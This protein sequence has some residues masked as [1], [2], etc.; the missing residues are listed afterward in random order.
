M[1]GLSQL[2]KL[3][4]A[5][6]TQDLLRS[7][8]LDIEKYL[9]EDK[10][11]SRF[12]KPTTSEEIW[13]REKER[14]P[15]KT[16]RN[17]AWAVNVYRSWAEHRNNQIETLDD[18][19]SSVPV[20]FDMMTVKEVD[21]W[22][23]RFILEAR[24]V[25]GKP[26]PANTLYSIATGLMRHFK[27]DIK[28]FDLNILS[29]NDANFS[30]FRNA[31]DS[32]MKEMT[33]AGIGTTKSAADPLTL[34][35]EEQLWSSG[36]IGFHSSQALS[37]AVFF[38]NCKVFGFRAMNE[39]V[40]L[41]IEQYEFGADET[42]EFVKFHGRVSKNVQGG[43]QQRKVNVKEIKQY[44]QECNA[45]CVVKLLREY[46]KCIPSSGRFYRKPL[47]SSEP[48]DIRFG[49][50][51]IGI[52]T[53]SK[54]LKTMC[55]AANI[56]LEGRRF[57]NHSGKVTCATRLYESGNFDEQI[58]MSRTGHR[59][60]AVRCYKRPSMSLMKSV[61]DALQPPTVLEPE[62]KKTKVTKGTEEE[63][64]AK[65]ADDSRR[66]LVNIKHGETTMTI[67]FD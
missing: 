67:R 38:Y 6:A 51:P 20:S 18:E 63:Q 25:D 53:L 47:P 4:V 19:Y 9:S 42:G 37:Y 54:Y 40:N 36:A 45:R 32:K 50:Q 30:S 62:S 58:I 23:T 15:V 10:G 12:E 66:C 8:S 7:E 35:D 49:N 41:S 26:Y 3:E 29:K 2:E 52:N 46:M 27:D 34:A 55:M 11:D 33:S 24:R 5:V 13:R 17:T 56:N 22:L 61:S 59:S 44:A 39:H 28:R 14:I 64:L 16:K 1:E 60:T 43:L 65:E 57:T 48:G 21:F 31:L